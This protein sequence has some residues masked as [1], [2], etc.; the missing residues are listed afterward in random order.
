MTGMISDNYSGIT[1]GINVTLQNFIYT[2]YSRDLSEKV[3]IGVK[4]LAKKGK[5]TGT[6]GFFGYRKC[7]D[8]IHKLE[9][10]PDAAKIVRK[11]FDMVIAGTKR[12][13]VAATL[14]KEGCADSGGL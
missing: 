3:K 10:D 4:M 2:L 13:D 7:A 8:D 5:Y 11:I 9:P 12:K 6:Y 14:N 1:G